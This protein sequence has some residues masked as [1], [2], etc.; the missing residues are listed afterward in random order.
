MQIRLKK[1]VK[2]VGPSLL[3]HT[4][5]RRT[6]LCPVSYGNLCRSVSPPL[7]PNVVKKIAENN[8]LKAILTWQIISL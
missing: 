8:S 1:N 2:D 4:L 6:V 7:Q 3:P 5:Y